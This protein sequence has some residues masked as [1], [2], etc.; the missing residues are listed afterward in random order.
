MKPIKIT[1]SQFKTLRRLLRGYMPAPRPETHDNATWRTLEHKQ[2]IAAVQGRWQ[3]ILPIA[4][5][6]IAH[7][8]RLRD[9]PAP[10][11]PS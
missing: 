3:A 9:E 4:Q 10:H 7:N 1:P 5:E 2:L 8:G 11:A 6:I